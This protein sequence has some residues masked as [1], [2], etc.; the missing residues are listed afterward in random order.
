MY[1]SHD[2][3]PFPEVSFLLLL[4]HKRKKNPHSPL[5]SK[6]SIFQR[7]LY[8]YDIPFCT[9]GLCEKKINAKS[10]RS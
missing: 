2:L 10:K 4:I 5:L 8:D 9:I 6:P 7:L 1:T 3:S